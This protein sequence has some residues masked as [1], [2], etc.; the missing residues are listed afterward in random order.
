MT[1]R[2]YYS[3]D[4]TKPLS[5]AAPYYVRTWKAWETGLDQIVAYTASTAICQAI[6]L[7]ELASMR[8]ELAD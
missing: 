7:V 3:R 4:S 1:A 5:C 6:L 2:I 8:L